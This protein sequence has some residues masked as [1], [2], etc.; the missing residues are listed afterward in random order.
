MESLPK[1][2]ELIK[3]ENERLWAILD[4]LEIK[5]AL[6]VVQG[7]LHDV[8]CEVRDGERLDVAVIARMDDKA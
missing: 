3:E 1:K 7:Q 4:W 5:M 2:W 8:I 6:P